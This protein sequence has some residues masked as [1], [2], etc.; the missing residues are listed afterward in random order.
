[1][2]GQQE[3]QSEENRAEEDKECS[4]DSLTQHS[5]IDAPA[6]KDR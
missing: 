1:M 2:Q 4:C 5:H 6:F 3:Q